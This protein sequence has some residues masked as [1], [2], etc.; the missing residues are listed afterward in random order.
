M[1]TL[2]RTALGIAA[3]TLAACNMISGADGVEFEQGTA[4]D[5]GSAQVSGSGGSTTT[6]GGNGTNGVGGGTTAG[7]GAGSTGTGAPA[8]LV[9]ADGVSITELKLYQGV[10]RP[11]M[12]NG[13]A[14]SS[15]VPIVAGRQS[16]LR[17]FYTAATPSSVTLR[18]SFE[19]GQPIEKVAQVSG[20]SSQAKL[21]STLNV[22]IPGDRIDGGGMRVELLDSSANSSGS[23]AQAA[24]PSSGTFPV[25]VQSVGATLKLVL[26]P[27]AYGADGSN[28]LPDTSPEQ[29][30]RYR[31]MF[32]R[33]YPVPDV[34]VT[35]KPA[36][37]WNSKVDPGGNGWDSLLNA[38]V[39]YRQQSGAKSDEYY[40][41]IFNAASSFATFCQSGCVAGLSFL[42]GPNDPM[43][44]AGIGIGFSGD[45]STG[46]AAHEIG[47]QHGRPHAPCGVGQ[48]VDPSFPHANGSIGAWGFDLVTSKLIEPTRPDFMS[49][50]HPEWVSDFNFKQLFNRIKLV[51]N[52]EWIGESDVLWDRVAIDAEGRANW[53]EPIMSTSAPSGE[54]TPIDVETNRGAVSLEG[55]YYPY[56]HVGG[57]VLLV[58]RLAPDKQSGVVPSVRGIGFEWLGRRVALAR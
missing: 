57:G 9:L 1:N 18:V 22:M 41:G 34:T 33:L 19:G 40:Y 30:E 16:F 14:A 53:L 31:K 28:R 7:T 10:E 37:N 21:E 25:P 44:R 54:L 36:V 6:G 15:D 32:F 23:N 39:D 3:L 20:T 13:S 17:V 42:A 49:Y 26:V 38:V 46:T 4:V 56:S 45:D 12:K 51:N 58:P 52:A 55:S 27:I 50:C 35:V 11:L 2:Q 8:E 5:S 47:H 43:A 29:I 48:G 24:Y